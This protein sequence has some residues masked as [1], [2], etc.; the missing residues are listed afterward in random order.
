[1]REHEHSQWQKWGLAKTLKNLGNLSLA[2]GEYA[3]AA[4]YF[5]QAWPHS[6]VAGRTAETL[7]ILLGWARLEAH[8]GR[9]LNSIEILARV[10]CDAATPH[11]VRAEAERLLGE[12]GGQL[13]PDDVEAARQRGQRKDLTAW[14]NP[15]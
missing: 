3:E 5:R 4:D 1:M 15:N 8:A 2:L 13:S 11:D 6:L 9:P 7:E 14:L 10:L 12:V